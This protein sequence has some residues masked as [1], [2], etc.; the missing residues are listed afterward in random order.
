MKVVFQFQ[1]ENF[2]YSSVQYGLMAMAIQVGQLEHNCSIYGPHQRTVVW[3]QG[4]TLGCKGCWNQDLWTSLGGAAMDVKQIVQDAIEAGDEG[5]TILGGEPLQQ[6]Q[7]TLA[8][9]L[10]AQQHDLGIFL[11]TGYDFDELEGDA[12]TCYEASDIVVAGRYIE[13]ERN[14]ELRWRGSSNQTVEFRTDRYKEFEFIEGNDVQITI[15]EDGSL[16]ILGY[17]DEALLNDLL[18]S[19]LS[20]DARGRIGPSSR[21]FSE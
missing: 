3:T 19:E 17:P 18:D 7:A 14:T 6:P 5:L 21:P 1:E 9:I 15:G 16:T 20:V 8:L 10:E 12:L 2:R 13:S 11:Y 4:C